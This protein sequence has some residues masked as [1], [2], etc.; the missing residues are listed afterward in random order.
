MQSWRLQ[1]FI[2]VSI[3][4]P[5]LLPKWFKEIRL[6][7]RVLP[8]DTK[9]HLRVRISDFYRFRFPPFTATLQLVNFFNI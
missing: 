6:R 2:S 1:M 3:S 4:A 9:Q 5:Q 8:T 7:L